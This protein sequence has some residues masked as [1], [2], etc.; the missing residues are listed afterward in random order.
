MEQLEWTHENLLK[1]IDQLKAWQQ[2]D[3]EEGNEDDI[4]TPVLDRSIE[5][6]EQLA[7]L[8]DPDR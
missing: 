5:T 2:F 4:V 6:L 8:V 1:I 3:Q 7:N